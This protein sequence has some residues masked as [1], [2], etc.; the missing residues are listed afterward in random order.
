MPAAKR[1][2]KKAA[3]KTKMSTAKKVKAK[4][5]RRPTVRRVKISDLVQHDRNANRGTERGRSS[6]DASLRAYGAGRGVLLDKNDKLMAG[7]KTTEA[8]E[9]AGVEEVIIVET[10][11]RTLV[12]TQRV[13]L[14]V[15]KDE[16]ARA[17]AIADNRTAE[18]GLNWDPVVLQ[19]EIE[20]GTDLS[21][22][23]NDVEMKRILSELIDSTTT[24]GESDGADASGFAI[25]IECTGEAQ[26]I[27]R[28]EELEEMGWESRAVVS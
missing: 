12:A 3:K 10:D 14:D 1:P 9:A 2:T 11:G 20:A 7:N 22:L 27:E 13:D 5:T 28:L 19:G 25:V 18:L 21:G 26:Q 6:I 17:L 4:K 23:F 8:A 16:D 24:S 15:D